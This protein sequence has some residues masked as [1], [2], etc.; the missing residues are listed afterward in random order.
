M[1]IALRVTNFVY[2]EPRESPQTETVGGGDGD[3]DVSPF[4]G[5]ATHTP[6][7]HSSVRT[8]SIANLGAA[9]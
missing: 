8:S 2:E 3:D 9:S 6:T 5:Y 4:L 7:T 1:V